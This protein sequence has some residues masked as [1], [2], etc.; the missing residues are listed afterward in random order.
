MSLVK[1]LHAERGPQGRAHRSGLDLTEHGGDGFV[2]AVLH[3]ADDARKL[4]EAK[5]AFTTEIADLAARERG[6]PSEGPQLLTFGRAFGPPQRAGHIPA[7]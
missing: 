1:V 4:R 5:F 6:G 7:P 2:E 3:G